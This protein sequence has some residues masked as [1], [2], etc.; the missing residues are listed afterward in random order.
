M[1]K[2]SLTMIHVMCYIKGKELGNLDK[3]LCYDPSGN[4]SK[5]EG[6]GTT[7]WSYFEDGE[8]KDFGDVKAS[9][10]DTIM[11]YWLGVI[12]LIYRFSPTIIVCESYKL[13]PGKAMAQSWSAMETPQMIGAI[14]LIAHTHGHTNFV[15]QDPSCKTRVADPVLEHKGII[16]KRNKN[17][18]C[19]DRMTNLHQRDAIRHGIYFLRYGVK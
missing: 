6:Q 10:Y 19:L 15:L 5:N 4:F 16:E 1:S 7:G 17:Y 2:F 14:R 11:M 13:Q 8:L 3:I 18:Y 12:E 9:D